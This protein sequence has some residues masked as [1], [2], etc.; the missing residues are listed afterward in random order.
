MQNSD[1]LAR[2]MQKS[3]DNEL[4]EP[5]ELL[6]LNARCYEAMRTWQNI[7]FQH[8]EG[9]VSPEEWESYRMNLDVL[10]RNQI[11]RDFWSKYDATFTSAFRDEVETILS[12]IVGSP[13]PY[14]ARHNASSGAE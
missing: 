8:I 2:I 9:L 3:F 12:A 10:L 6:R 11:Y 1:D 14:T 7:Y 5:H 13:D 4:L